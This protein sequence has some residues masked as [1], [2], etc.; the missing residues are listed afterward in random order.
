ML[1]F[2]ETLRSVFKTKLSKFELEIDI[3]VNIRLF[4]EKVEKVMNFD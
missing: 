1:V 3:K 2:F 4:I